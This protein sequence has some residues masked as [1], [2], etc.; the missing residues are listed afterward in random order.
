VAKKLDAELIVEF[1]SS[2]E[3]YD[4]VSNLDVD[5]IQGYYIGKPA[6]NLLEVY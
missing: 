3:I 4:V 5:Y 2:K 1:V 6:G